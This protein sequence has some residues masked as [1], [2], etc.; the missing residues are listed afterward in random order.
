MD[1]SYV[2]WMVESSIDVVKGNFFL[3]LSYASHVLLI[4]GILYEAV[5][6]NPPQNYVIFIKYCKF[7]RLTAHGSPAASGAASPYRNT[8]MCLKVNFSK[9]HNVFYR[10]WGWRAAKELP[11]CSE[12]QAMWKTIE[13]NEHWVASRGMLPVVTSDVVLDSC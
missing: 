1:C 9:T 3:S 10:I 11:L 13:N 2:S 4:R 5:W 6:N 7:H 8:K 12:G